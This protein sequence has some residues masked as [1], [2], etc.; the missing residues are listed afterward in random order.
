MRNKDRVRRQREK[1][2]KKRRKNLTS[3]FSKISSFETPK[4]PLY[5]TIDNLFFS[6]NDFFPS[7]GCNIP[8]IVT[9]RTLSPPPP[10]L[11]KRNERKERITLGTKNYR[12]EAY[13]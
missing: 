9:Q 1:E 4:L 10:L 6:T 5:I 8:Q 7:L 13:Q 11:L 12:K 2:E 3:T